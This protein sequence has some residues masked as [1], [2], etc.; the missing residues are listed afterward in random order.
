MLPKR[1]LKRV[2]EINWTK[3]FLISFK[4]CCLSIKLI[5]INHSLLLNGSPGR[6]RRLVGP[7]DLDLVPIGFLFSQSLCQHQLSHPVDTFIPG[8]DCEVVRL[9][10]FYYVSQFT[11]LFA[12]WAGRYKLE[13]KSCVL[14]CFN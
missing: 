2:T 4:R 8:L 14:W 9:L 12:V 7:V 6:L 13:T 5:V 11:R 10:A 3:P 1:V